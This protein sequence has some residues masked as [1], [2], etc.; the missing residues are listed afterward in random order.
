MFST[1]FVIKIKIFHLCHTRIV[2][3]AIVWHSCRSCITRVAHISLVLHLCS[4]CSTRVA[5]V[6]ISCCKI[7]YIRSIWFDFIYYTEIVF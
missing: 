5:R 6:W 3:V 4:L 1:R 7:E 2:R